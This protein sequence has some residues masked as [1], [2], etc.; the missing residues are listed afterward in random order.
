MKVV[1]TVTGRAPNGGAKSRG[2]GPMLALVALAVMLT[3]SRAQAEGER[4]DVPVKYTW[5]LVDLY[6]TRQAWAEALARVE[7]RVDD[8]QP[9][10]GHLGDSAATLL[11]ALLTREEIAKEMARV[12]IYAMLSRDTDTRDSETGGMV[13]QT[14]NLENRLSTA[15]AWVEPEILA[16]GDEKVKSFMTREPALAAFRPVLDDIMRRRPHTLSPTEERV[17]T[18][19]SEMGDTGEAVYGL[20]TNA[21]L[22]FPEV[23]LSDGRK[24][25]LDQSGYG[26]YRS[27][28]LRADRDLVFK[29]FWQTFKAFR[30]TLGLTLY[31]QVKS[32]IVNK[33][34]R[35]YPSSLAAALDGAN[36]PVTVYTQ[37]VSD[38]NAN[39]ETLH[40]YLRLRKRMLGVEQLRYEDLYAPTVKAVDMRF[41]PEQ[42]MEVTLAAVAPLGP[43]YTSVLKRA[44]DER[45]VDFLPTTGKRSGA[46]S[47]GS[48][49]DV[50]PYQLL[51]YNG[52]YD[53]V[54]TLAHESGHSM[55][56]WFSNK[57]QRF[58]NARY[59]IFV[60][61]VA[62]TLNENLLFHYTL[63]RAGDDSTRL[64]LL[65]ERL[66][67]FRTTLFRQTLFAEFELR[68]HEMAEQG[69]PLT[70]DRLS[71]LYLELLRRYYG[72]D[73]GVCGVDELY[74]NEWAFVP[75]FY[76]NFY[77]YQYATSLMASTAIADRI[78]A[79]APKGGTQA[80]DAYLRMLSAGSSTYPVDLLKE[81]G[82]D[83][84]TSAPFRSSMREMNLIMDQ[85]ETLLQKGRFPP[86]R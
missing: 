34:L 38:V 82:V 13:S 35:H 4:K 17:F 25:R 14:Q 53:D 83:M 68:I 23:T 11:K 74:G 39:L 69:Q 21:D 50:H 63:H 18:R 36:V 43:A 48:A 19:C 9:C 73:Q 16:L 54:S 70:G 44:Y 41:T 42:A 61:E 2:I 27:S 60:A 45:W 56:S 72:H 33:D 57:N 85:M 31:N 80:R 66:E 40:R 15:W 37:L 8:L 76:Y 71:A 58:S 24:V 47:A 84:T 30:R 1:V 46:Y 51:N 10:K 32:H 86:P 67:G 26:R 59:S 29:T 62:S 3:L 75:H 12:G 52:K 7:K 77:V 65:G 20:F 64:F 6:P 22:P 81:T 55:H 78:R 28:T 49:Y 79:E 5:N